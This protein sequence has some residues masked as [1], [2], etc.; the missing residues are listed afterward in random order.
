ME[1]G[2]TPPQK[3][4]KLAEPGQPAD[5]WCLGRQSDPDPEMDAYDAIGLLATKYRKWEGGKSLTST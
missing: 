4:S 5:A 3:R 2:Q 1:P